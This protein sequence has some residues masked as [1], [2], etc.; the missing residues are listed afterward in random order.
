LKTSDSSRSD[1]EKLGKNLLNSSP[2]LDKLNRHKSISENQTLRI[3]NQHQI[4]GSKM[5]SPASDSL[6][7]MIPGGPA[8]ER[9]VL[10]AHP[11][12]SRVPWSLSIGQPSTCKVTQ[13]DKVSSSL[14]ILSGSD[15]LPN[16]TRVPA[17]EAQYGL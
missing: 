9:I 7:Q 11:L 17:G 14:I 2:I 1:Y 4:R 15:M 8:W 10:L 13:V 16:R 6:A 5:V 12:Q 3:K